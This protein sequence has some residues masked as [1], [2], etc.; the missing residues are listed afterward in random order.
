VPRSQSRLNRIIPLVVA[1]VLT[2]AALWPLGQ[3]RRAKGRALARVDAVAGGGA[4]SCEGLDAALSLRVQRL[5]PWLSS[6]ETVG[7][8]GAGGASFGTGVKW[9]GHSTTGGMFQVIEQ[10]NYVHLLDERAD[11]ISHHPGDNY[12]LSTQITKDLTDKWNLGVSIPVIYK[13]Y[14]NW[15]QINEDLS[16]GGLGDISALI[17]RRLGRINATTLT[18]LVGFPTGTY[19]EKYKTADLTPDQQLGFGRFTAGLL[20]D[21]TLDQTWGLVVLGG[22]AGYRGGTNDQGNYR[23]PS[24]SL[25]A[26]TGYF[27]GPL[28]PAAGLTFTGFTGQDTTGPLFAD[29]LDAPVATA[30]MNASIEWSTD[31]VAIL[32][33]GTFPYAVRGETWHAS[34]KNFGWQPWT[35]A[36]GLS[37]SPF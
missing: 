2:G 11:A 9:I 13:Y 24:G 21:H 17:T 35:V 15:K 31:W 1:V 8:C 16:N 28:V 6:W 4:S 5:G 29:T 23:A 20:L 12:I 7:G 19:K 26:Y 36:L 32:V 10:G 30:A 27:L 37:F 22:A 14:Y 33:G 34:G 25:W 3:A 18:G